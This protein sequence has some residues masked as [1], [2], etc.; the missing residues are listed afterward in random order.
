MSRAARAFRSAFA[1]ESEARRWA[2]RQLLRRWHEEPAARALAH[3]EGKAPGRGTRSPDG[4]PFKEN[5]FAVVAPLDR[6]HVVR[7]GLALAC[8]ALCGAAILYPLAVH[9]LSVWA[10]FGCGL[11]AAVIGWLFL[12][13][14]AKQAWR[15]RL[16][17]VRAR[18]ATRFGG[19]DG[20]TAETC[21]VLA[22]VT[23]AV[24]PAAELLR[25]PVA[26]ATAPT[27][28]PAATPA[29]EPHAHVS[30]ATRLGGLGAHIPLRLPHPVLTAARSR[31]SA[32]LPEARGEAEYERQRD[33][34][35]LA[36]MLR[37]LQRPHVFILWIWW[38][39][40]LAVWVLAALA[41]RE[42][43]VWR[44]FFVWLLMGFSLSFPVDG[45][46]PSNPR[47]G[48]AYLSGAF[49]AGSPAR[50]EAMDQI[51]ALSGATIIRELVVRLRPPA[52]AAESTGPPVEQ[53]LREAVATLGGVPQGMPLPSD[54]RPPGTRAPAAAP[55]PRSRHVPARRRRGRHAPCRLPFPMPRRTTGASDEKASHEH[56]TGRSTWYFAP[57]AASRSRCA[58]WPGPRVSTSPSSSRPVSAVASSRASTPTNSTRPRATSSQ[59]WTETKRG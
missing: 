24:S 40:P 47:L 4:V 25:N 51:E 10:C 28:G 34:D 53:A 23:L 21:A 56:A 41:H 11:A 16:G 20:P 14:P 59:A 9:R 48:P 12:H 42:M 32:R 30:L 22:Q 1:P 39:F 2:F 5:V 6:A 37:R 15:D 38:L 46:P 55:S 29:E 33:L 54:A 19:P 35:A 43:S 45:E 44:G 36:G 31:R 13:A 58:G 57:T 8:G 18:F 26:S 7:R 3:A 49:P 17:G 50:A 52:A 27:E